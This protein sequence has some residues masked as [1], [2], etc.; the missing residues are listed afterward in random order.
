[1]AQRVEDPALSLLRLG[2]VLWRGFS[3][4]S[5]NLRMP[6]ARPKKFALKKKKKKKKTE[7]VN[8]QQFHNKNNV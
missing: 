8:P 6:Q 5:G 2:S 3:P 7:T 1:M 4:W